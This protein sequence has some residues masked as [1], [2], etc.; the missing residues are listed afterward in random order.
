MKIQKVSS[1]EVGLTNVLFSPNDE[2]EKRIKEHKN[3][4]A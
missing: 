4:T 2:I 1:F 3:K